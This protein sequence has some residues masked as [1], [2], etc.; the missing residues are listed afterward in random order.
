MVTGSAACG[1]GMAT[2]MIAAPSRQ[3]SAETLPRTTLGTTLFTTGLFITGQ[4]S[5]AGPA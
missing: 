4:A 5:L 2:I 3:P 1:A